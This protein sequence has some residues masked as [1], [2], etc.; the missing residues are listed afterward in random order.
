[1]PRLPEP[2]AVI[3]DDEALLRFHLKRQLAE[4]WPELELRGEAADGD[5]A[6]SLIEAERPDV[7]FLDIRMPG[8]SGLEVAAR[9]RHD[10]QL[11]F[12]TAYDE[13]A[14]KA[15]ETA[16]ADYLLKPL[17]DERLARTVERLRARLAERQPLPDAA[18]LL[19]Q[20]GA[21]AAP[22]A[23]RYLQWIHAARQDSVRI[24][25]V[26]EVLYFEADKKYTTVVTAREQL[27]IRKPLKELEQELDPSRFW[28]VHRGLIVNAACLD[29][30]RRDLAGRLWVRLRGSER[31]LPVSRAF[32]HLFKQM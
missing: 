28:R 10:C 25:P 1:M 3:A 23:P 11:V 29:S 17:S 18:A 8:L 6:L 5:S 20:L 4:I 7:V 21:L 27:L 2:T 16:A 9:L 12:V 30:S 31:E 19:R 24:V 14:L 32:A 22:V 26:E 13:F 15:F